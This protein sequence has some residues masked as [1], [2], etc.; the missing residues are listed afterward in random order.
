MTCIFQ[1]NKFD[2]KVQ[3]FMGNNTDGHRV[4]GRWVMRGVRWVMR[5]VRWVMRGVRQSTSEQG[6]SEPCTRLEFH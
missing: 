6:Y 5:G 4:D 2:L 3:V 1:F